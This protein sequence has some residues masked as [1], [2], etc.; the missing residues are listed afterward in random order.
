MAVPAGEL[1]AVLVRKRR[2]VQVRPETPKPWYWLG[3]KCVSCFAF[4]VCMRDSPLPKGLFSFLF[5]SFL[6]A[7]AA[8]YFFFTLWMFYKAR[9]QF[10]LRTLFLVTFAVAVL[11]STAQYIP[12]APLLVFLGPPVAEWASWRP[13][14][15]SSAADATAQSQGTT[16]A[17]DGIAE[18]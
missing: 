18:K 8:A 3:I 16:P 15:P 2:K 4:V 6:F 7:V 11:C 1:V 10:T 5:D 9:Q 13:P 17:S 12:I 14:S